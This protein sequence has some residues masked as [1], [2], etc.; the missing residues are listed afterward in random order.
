MKSAFLCSEKVRV[1]SERGYTVE[2]SGFRVTP[3]TIETEG[4][5]S[6]PAQTLRYWKLQQDL[7]KLQG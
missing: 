1:M 6:T 2:L 7:P 4:I 5:C 3:H